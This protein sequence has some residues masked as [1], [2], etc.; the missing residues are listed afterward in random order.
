MTGAGCLPLLRALRAFA[1]LRNLPD[2][3]EQ[4][5]P[6]AQ[7]FASRDA[8]GVAHVRHVFFGGSTIHIACQ[9]AE[10]RADPG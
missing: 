8:F 3:G 6:K 1:Q 5:Q 7:D 10:N 9:Q 4:R 2:D